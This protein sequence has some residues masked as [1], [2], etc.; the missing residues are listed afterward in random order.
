MQPLNV[1]STIFDVVIQ[2]AEFEIGDNFGIGIATVSA[3]GS[4]TI[5]SEQTYWVV[6]DASKNVDEWNQEI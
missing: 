3:P 2:N 1:R 6:T 5:N 4:H